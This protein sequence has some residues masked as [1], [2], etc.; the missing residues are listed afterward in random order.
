MN[1]KKILCLLLLPFASALAA[2]KNAPAP[3]EASAQNEAPT[4]ESVLASQVQDIVSSDRSPKEQ[5][6]LIS[7]AVRLAVSSAIEGKKKPAER[8]AAAM[9]LAAAAAKAAPHFA[10]TI[11][12]A[13]SSLPAFADLD[14][15]AEQIQYAVSTSIESSGE[16]EIA[17]P[18][19]N[20]ARPAPKPEFGGSTRG[21]TVVSPAS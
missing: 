15:A 17:N 19:V 1:S 6:K 18:A 3:V 20:P 8:L 16:T 21:E 13:V 14:G 12:S 10:T 2:N 7:S 9:E 4:P 11:T 5:G